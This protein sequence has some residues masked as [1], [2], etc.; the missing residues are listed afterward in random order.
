MSY[1]LFYLGDSTRARCYAESAA[2]ISV[3]YC[4]PCAVTKERR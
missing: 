4:R 1:Y 2:E 3:R